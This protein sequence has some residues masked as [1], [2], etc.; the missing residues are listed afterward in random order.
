MSFD[1]ERMQAP[2][3]VLARHQITYQNKTLPELDLDAVLQRH[4]QLVL[5]DELAHTNAPGS[6]HDKR[7][8]D[9]EE[10]LAAG[11]DVYTTLNIQHLES[12]NDAVAQITGVRVRETIP[13]HVL[14]E[15]DEI[16]L[17]DLPPDDLVRRMNE[18]RVYVPEQAARAI[19]QFFRKGNLTALR[20]MALR[21]TASRVDEQLR[22]Y[23]QTQ[24]IAG[25]WAA[26]DRLLVCVGPSPLSAR[27]VRATR[28]LAEELKAEWLALYVETPD[29]ASL[30]PAAQESLA[31]NLKLAEQLGAQVGSISGA[32]V[33]EATIAY[34]KRHNVTKIVV[35]KPLRSRLHELLH[36]SIVDQIIHSSGMIDVYVLSSSGE[37]SASAALPAPSRPINWEGY[38]KSVGLVAAATM[39]SLPLRSVVQPTNLV[40][41]YLSAVLL[42][43]VYL[44]RNEALL[45]SVLSTM[46]FDFFCVPP[47]LTFAVS[48]TQY[49]LTFAGLL[50]V[51]LVISSL[52]TRTRAHAEAAQRREIQAV[53]LYQL[54]RA[55]AATGDLPT[56]LGTILDHIAK[57][58]GAAAVVLLPSE[59]GLQVT[60]A[61]KAPELDADEVAVATWS[62]Q[63]GQEAGLGTDTLRGAELRY[64]PLRSGTTAIGVLGVRLT[65]RDGYLLPEERR[66]LESTASL[67]ALAIERIHLAEKAGQAELL[68]ATESLQSA[69]LNSISHDLRTP[70]ASITGAL[71]GLKEGAT[72][73]EEFRLD[74]RSSMELVDTALGEAERLNR[75][76]GN[77]LDMS[78]LEAGALRLHREPCDLQDLVGAVLGQLGDRL[79]SHPVDVCLAPDLPLVPLDFVLIAQVL[80]NLLDNA[81]KYSPPAT[82]IEVSARQDNDRVTIR[83][84]DRG[85]GVPEEDLERVFDKF[86][87]VNR[88]DG[89]TGTGLGLAISR[90]IVEAH[91]GSI[92]AQDRP[93]GGLEVLISLP[94]ET[95]EAMTHD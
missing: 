41:L 17:V 51:G 85:P 61:S 77:L 25:P 82:L 78:R 18:G 52:A 35:G 58:F 79:Q 73:P 67:A 90:G 74:Q 56:I 5:V 45:A 59:S 39:V 72:G 21:R 30:A 50:V 65:Q 94:L 43:A 19:D 4:P 10:I 88:T 36:G 24:S 92:K 86:Q 13:D 44:G 68:R 64:L 80:V 76:V 89:A 69:L 9:V 54:S 38:A 8:Q 40:M 91:G 55:L 22:S 34:A 48:D 37:S 26:A 28:R 29:Q 14:D 31:Q 49:L 47:H 83:V 16:D 6:R 33:A 75:L 20:E 7:Y 23:M 57:T 53:N 11:I 71:S 2:L 3:E 62:L 70:L 32:S 27:L 60:A 95:P 93:G 12:L 81:A 42:A 63:H 87:R 84:A 15:A 46:A 1:R 66:E